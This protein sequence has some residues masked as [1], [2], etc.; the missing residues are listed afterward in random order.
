MGK[1]GARKRIAGS[2]YLLT[3]LAGGALA[4]A[5][6]AAAAQPPE[7]LT[8][9]AAAVAQGLP[10][11]QRDEP[12]LRLSQMIARPAP[13][14]K[15]PLWMTRPDEAPQLRPATRLAL[16]GPEGAEPLA[17]GTAAAAPEL[18]GGLPVA[19]GVPG[20]VA[21]GAAT[22]PAAGTGIGGLGWEIPPIRWGGSV[23]YT[24]QRSSNDTGY[25][26][27]T[28][29][30][31]SN[32]AASSYIYAPWFAR[33]SGRLGITTNS[34]SSSG[35]QDGA[36]DSNRSSNM[37]GGGEVNMFS[38]SRYPF[39]AYFDRSDSRASGTI[40]T[41][42]YVSNRYGV[43]QS[44]R[45]EDGMSTGNFMLDRNTINSSDGRRDDVTALSG[46]YS[47]TTGI[48][49]NNVNARY[50]LGEQSG[51]GNRASLVGLNSS[52]I[53]N[54]SDTLNLGGIMNY[55][56]SDIRTAS[57]FGSSSSSRG[58]YLQLYTYGSW[59]PEFEDLEDLPLTLNGG[60]RYT[61]QETSFD[62]TGFNAQTLGANLSGL[63]RFSRNLS[64]SANSAI[65]QITQ[66]QGGSQTLTQLG[67]GVNYNGDVLTF[68]KYSYNWN[69]G[70]NANWQSALGNTE[71]NA[72]T[73]GQFSHNLSR[74]V[75]L[76]PGQALS[77]NAA[78]T[79]NSTNSQRVGNSQSLSHTL[80]AN[81]GVAA[82]ERFS[83]SLSSMVSDVRTTG[84]V[85]QNY[86][87]LNI[88]FYGQGQIS[89]VSS[90][91]VNMTFNWSDQSYQ[92]VDA[93]GL[94]VTQNA[95]RMT[96]NGS[97][98]Y[99]HMRFAGLRGLRY[100][101][102]FTADSRLRD[103]RLYGNVNGDVERARYSLIN[104]LEYRIGLLDFRLSLVNNDVGGKKNALLFFQVARQI[105]SY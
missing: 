29:G 80:A 90:A 100:N 84:Y 51:T 38:S 92:T 104:R 97:A 20:G 18:V 40:V 71:A 16:T 77:L 50:S 56:D 103:D 39:R 53:A 9:I 7:P 78:Q 6:E 67:T 72:V 43:S 75:M 69:T 58:R 28:Q 70:A 2:R 46:T 82:G 91:T 11:E 33:V 48:V 93:F 63:Y 86:R 3:G 47:T 26:S 14:R 24:Y 98:A 55:A 41:T 62:G 15:P 102:I 34:T 44:L 105:G 60:L 66:A 37:V 1:P 68:G 99:S 35:S 89:Q 32:L 59:L 54:V 85:E 19:G 25:N 23:G 22:N 36:G 30:L 21:S 27:V 13:G 17:G 74:V 4:F 101:L 65:T 64:A 96:L 52:H 73:S 5:G 88:G 42:D 61:N 83:G 8:P 79:L 87:V 45:S 57:G 95:Q 10:L 94:P 76:S 49:Q 12:S 81:L 31:F